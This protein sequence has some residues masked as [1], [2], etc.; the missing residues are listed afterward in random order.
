[1]LG[2]LQRPGHSSLAP[3]GDQLEGAEHKLRHSRGL[4]P[5]PYPDRAV[6]QETSVSFCPW[7]ATGRRG[8]G[9]NRG[10]KYTTF[11]SQG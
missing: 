1:M 11:H 8:A 4:L 9:R 3:G 5:L 2:S 6:A 7:T 10:H